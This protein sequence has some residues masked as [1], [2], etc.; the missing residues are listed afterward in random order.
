[1]KVVINEFQVKPVIDWNK[2]QLL[3]NEHGNIILSTGQHL[4]NGTFSAINLSGNVSFSE[5]YLKAAYFPYDGAITI[6]ND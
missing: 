3:I 2:Q 4:K 6:Q 1:M 5:V